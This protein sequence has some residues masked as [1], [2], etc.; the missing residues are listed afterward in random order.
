MVSNQEINSCDRSTFSIIADEH[1]DLIGT[2]KFVELAMTGS[3]SFLLNYLNSHCLT[4]AFPDLNV[5]SL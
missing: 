2:P 3:V 5:S 4:I 1:N